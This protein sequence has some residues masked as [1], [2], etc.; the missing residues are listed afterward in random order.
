MKPPIIL[1]PYQ[2]EGARF[3]AERAASYNADDPGLGKSAQA[4]TASLSRGAT[5]ARVICPASLRV[6]WMRE[7]AK[8]G[9]SGI[10]LDI[11]SYEGAV[12]RLKENDRRPSDV[13]IVDE[14]HYLQSRDAQRTKAVLGAWRPL[15]GSVMFLSGTPARANPSQLYPV[16]AA[17]FP[18]AIK[19]RTGRVLDFW[20]FANRYCKVENNGFGQKIS[21]G[22]NLEELRQRI[23]PYFIRRKKAEVLSS[24]P[25][26]RIGT[27]TVEPT[28]ISRDQ[29]KA[30]SELEN[31]IKSILATSGVEGLHSLGPHFAQLRRIIGMAKVRPTFDLLM[32]ELV[33]TDKIVVFAWHVDVLNAMADLLKKDHIGFSRVDGST[34]DRQHEV[35]KFQSDEGCR[36]FLGNIM[37]AGTGLTLTAAQSLLMMESSWTPADNSQAIM[38]IHRIGQKRACLAR[39]VALAGSIDERIAETCEEKTRTLTQLGF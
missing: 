27:V 15:A 21:G 38:R 14:A 19:T 5:T 7:F 12:R 17:A 8:F 26:I 16:L 22:R 6:N 20:G 39:F 18:E 34:I 37:A 30:E 4:I 29:R 35:D 23:S 9:G 10:D 13:L 3:M 32:E 28:T 24:L 11:M 31:Q 2:V 25:E 1:E 33:Y 36:V